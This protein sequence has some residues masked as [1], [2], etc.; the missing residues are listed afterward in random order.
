LNYVKIITKQTLAPNYNENA[1]ILDL[2]DTI[3]DLTLMD[4]KQPTLK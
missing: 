4:V 1:Q 2:L 3:A